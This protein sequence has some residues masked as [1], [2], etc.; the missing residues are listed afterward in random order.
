MWLWRRKTAATDDDGEGGQGQWRMTTA[1][2]IGW[3]TTK[4]TDKSGR[5][6]TAE[7]RS[8]YDGCGGGRWWRWTTT[9]AN[10]D[11]GEG[12]QQQ[13]RWQTTTTATAD[14]DN[15]DGGGRQRQTMTACKIRRQTTRGKE[16]SGQQTTAALEPAGQRA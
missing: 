2:R 13:R 5:Q 10:D 4:G 6:E 15:G 12:R 14:N 9:A 16:E 7:T 3:Q 1:C 11:N 8:G